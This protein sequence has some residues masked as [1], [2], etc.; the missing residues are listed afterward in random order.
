MSVLEDQL[1]TREG[2]VRLLIAEGIDV[3]WS[4]DSVE[5]MLRSTALDRP[6]AVIVDVRLPPTFTDEGLRAAAKVRRRHPQT[7][8]LVLSQYV[9]LE[10]ARWLLDASTRAIGYL[11]KDRLLE[12][13]T[14]RTAL[15]RIVAGECVV[16][17]ELVRE[18]LARSEASRRFPQ[19][20]DREEDVLTAIAEGL[21]NARIATRLGISE[22]TVELHAKRVFDKLVIPVEDGANRRVIAVLRYL[23]GTRRDAH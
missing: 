10:F 21:T 23:Q 14:L 19:L 3:P 18:L 12:A 1:L 5:G 22:R 7:A 13:T 16:D 20:S 9:E 8:V 6:D 11:L 15:E 4:G 2:I 17:P